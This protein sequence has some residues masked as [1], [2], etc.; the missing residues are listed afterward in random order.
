MAKMVD[1]GDKDVVRREAT[2]EGLLVLKTSTVKAIASGT[3]KKGDA[4]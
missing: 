2:A 3:I 1:V 4:K